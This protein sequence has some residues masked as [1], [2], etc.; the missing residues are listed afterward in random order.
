M[1]R[2]MTNYG[3]RGIDHLPL[4]T[5]RK[6]GE[7]CIISVTEEVSERVSELVSEERRGP[8][9]REASILQKHLRMTYLSSFEI[10]EQI[11]NT[12]R[13]GGQRYVNLSK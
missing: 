7:I 11:K 12:K 4:I 3:K 9:Y 2:V 10:K 13:G 1:A 5:A 8:S 6:S